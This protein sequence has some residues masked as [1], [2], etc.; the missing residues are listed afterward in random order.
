M[1]DKACAIMKASEGIENAAAFFSS[2]CRELTIE[3]GEAPKWGTVRTLREN[4]YV[5]L[6]PDEEKI[7]YNGFLEQ[8]PARDTGTQ[9]RKGWVGFLSPAQILER[10]IKQE[11]HYKAKTT[12]RVLVPDPCTTEKEI[13]GL[14]AQIA[15][16]KEKAEAGDSLA[17]W[18]VVG[19]KSRIE[20]L[21]GKP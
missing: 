1:L 7:N 6:R 21:T 10:N 4:N 12:S 17:Q 16:Y 18:V 19:S 11:A 14:H 8:Q 15:K 5:I 20:K 3:R 9:K 13:E 2:K